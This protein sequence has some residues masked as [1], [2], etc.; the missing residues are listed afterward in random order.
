MITSTNL[1]MLRNLE[2]FQVMSN[3]LAYLKAEN[4][5]E[6]KLA[7]PVEK[8]TAQLKIYDDLLVLERGNL[9]SEKLNQANLDRDQALR[10]MLRVIRAY[11]SFPEQEKADAALK[12]L[13]VFEKYGKRIDKLPYLQESGALNNLLQDL[14]IA[15]NQSAITLLHIDDWLDKL[16]ATTLAF[17]QLFSGR[18]SDNSTKLSGKVKEVRQSVQEVFEELVTLVN[19]YEI[20][21]GP[22]DY[23]ALSAKINEA[24]NYARQQAARRGPR[25]KESGTSVDE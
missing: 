20:V 25:S 16:K 23:A 11:T 6:L 14:E 5:E 21:Y 8:L 9:L 7:L 2:Y 22:A 13:R 18:E 3:V 19:A 4:V 10:S 17:D 24:V 12:L 1:T 15:E